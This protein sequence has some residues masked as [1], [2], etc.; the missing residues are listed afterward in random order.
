MYIGTGIFL[1]VVGAIL[2]WG[3]AVSYTHLD[4]YKRQLPDQGMVVGQQDP[5]RR[6]RSSNG[7]H[8]GSFLLSLIH[9]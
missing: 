2:N 6:A 8:E 4:V 5:G 1:L 9:I 3:V 7:G